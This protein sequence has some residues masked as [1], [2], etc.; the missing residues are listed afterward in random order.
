M[1]LRIAIVD[2][3]E[4]ARRGIRKR[5][6]QHTDVEIVAECESGRQAIDVLRRSSPDLVFLDVQMPG[7]SGFDVIESVGWERFPQVIFVTAHDQYAIRAFEVNALDYLLKP[8]DDE[9]FDLALQ[10]ARQAVTQKKQ[11]DIGRRLA[12][13]VGKA[14]GEVSPAPSRF[15][16]MVVRSSGRVIFLRVPEIDWVEAA[17]DYVTLHVGKKEWL[18]RETIGCIEN[19]LEPRGFA[20]IHRSTIVNLERVSE[21]QPLDNGEY[22]VLLRDGTELKLSRSYRNALSRL[23]EIRA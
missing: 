17:G 19:K 13:V 2:D 16:R 6:E 11:S 3:E 22:R 10:R 18:M 7:K 23:A 9:R 21:M 15:D 20:R 1:P 8:V 12:A 14:G 4:L 5:L